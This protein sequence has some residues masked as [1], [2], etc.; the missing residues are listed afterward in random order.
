MSVVCFQHWRC[1]LLASR[2]C[3]IKNK[4]GAEPLDPPWGA[5]STPQ[6]NPTSALGERN[7]NSIFNKETA[8]QY[9]PG[10]TAEMG[11]MR[12]HYVGCDTCY[13][14]WLKDGNGHKWSSSSPCT[15]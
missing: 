7:E 5:H 10:K 6:K 13:D 8:L 4:S 12:D 9:F 15:I 14:K 1:S 3:K 11:Y 2:W